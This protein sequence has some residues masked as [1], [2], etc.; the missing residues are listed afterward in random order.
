LK[1]VRHDILTEL[2]EKRTQ[3]T[4]DS[5]REGA[6]ARGPERLY[7]M[8]ETG[9]CNMAFDDV[10][11]YEV[12][13]ENIK[14]G[15]IWDDL[16]EYIETYELKDQWTV[17][18]TEDVADDIMDD[19]D[20]SVEKP[21]HIRITIK[22]DQISAQDERDEVKGFDTQTEVEIK[23]FKKDDTTARI[24]IQATKGDISHWKQYFTKEET[25]LKQQWISNGT[26]IQHQTQELVAA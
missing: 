16:E 5:S 15:H 2:A 9:Y 3:S 26:V 24:Q 20:A 11:A 1:Q 21:R 23:F 7:L 10:E 18:E 6:S 19:D 4:A 12:L 14:P 25:G 13:T 22:P 8:R 17:E